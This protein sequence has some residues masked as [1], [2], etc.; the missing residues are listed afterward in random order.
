MADEEGLNNLIVP[1]LLPEV[2]RKKRQDNETTKYVLVST[3]RYPPTIRR[4][5][6]DHEG[7][8]TERKET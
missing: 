4:I 6:N 5:V 8:G 3:V 2:K 7:E 1:A